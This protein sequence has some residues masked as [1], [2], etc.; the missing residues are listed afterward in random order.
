MRLFLYWIL[1]SYF[2]HLSSQ[3]EFFDRIES[4]WINL[5]L[6]IET[7]SLKE[8][9]SFEISFHFVFELINLNLPIRLISIYTFCRCA[10]ICRFDSTIICSNNCLNRFTLE[11]FVHFLYFICIFAFVFRFA[12]SP[13]LASLSFGTLY[14]RTDE[15]FF[16]GKK[17]IFAFVISSPINS[18]NVSSDV[19]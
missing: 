14:K 5:L 19:Y 8:S 18:R 3:I 7:H 9:F 1:F 11:W 10:L 12:R 6:R 2:C 4:K 16:D 15:D 13:L 17:S